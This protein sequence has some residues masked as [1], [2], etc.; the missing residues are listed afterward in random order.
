MHCNYRHFTLV[1]VVIAI[2][3]ILVVVTIIITTTIVSL[4]RF[5]SWAGPMGRAKQIGRTCWSD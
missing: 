1:T 4:I 5:D 3:V 2:V